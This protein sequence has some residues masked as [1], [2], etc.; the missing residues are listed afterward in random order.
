MYGKESL[1]QV[2]QEERIHYH[3]D[4]RYRRYLCNF[5]CY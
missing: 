4:L 5:E 2:V 1:A 3:L